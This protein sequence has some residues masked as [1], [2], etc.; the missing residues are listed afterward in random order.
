M[1]ES[2]NC[3]WKTSM[4][5]IRPASGIRGPYWVAYRVLDE[6]GSG[7]DEEDQ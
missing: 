5:T 3:F 4:A 2:G 1:E 6:L 7:I